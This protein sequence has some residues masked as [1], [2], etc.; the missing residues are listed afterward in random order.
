[1]TAA[2]VLAN[3][4]VL[5]VPAGSWAEWVGAVG[6][7]GAVGWGVIAWGRD[8]R[9]AL[10][11]EESGQARLVGG[12][13]LGGG[14]GPVLVNLINASRFPV[15][16]VEAVLIGDGHRVVVCGGRQSP[17]MVVLPQDRPQTLTIQPPVNNV[18]G[19]LR[20]LSMTTTESAG[21]STVPRSFAECPGTSRW[22][23]TRRERS[24]L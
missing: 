12:Y 4:P 17:T 16:K 5:W 15:V 21:T 24:E 7:V 2:V 18:H 1:M 13:T 14:T 3:H 8:R 9:R 19:I 22:S 23:T 20:S 6:T 10:D 11:L